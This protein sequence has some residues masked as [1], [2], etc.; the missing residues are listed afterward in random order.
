MKQPKRVRAVL[1]E[2]G[3]VL[4]RSKKHLIFKL[5]NGHIVS[6]AASPSDGM[7]GEHNAIGDIRRVAAKPPVGAAR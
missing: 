4:V 3:A 1:R 2:V 7:Y 6:L 5:P